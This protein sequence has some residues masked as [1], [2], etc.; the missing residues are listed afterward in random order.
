[1]K[2]GREKEKEGELKICSFSPIFKMILMYKTMNSSTDI[3]LQFPD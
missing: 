1:M 2:K 3:V